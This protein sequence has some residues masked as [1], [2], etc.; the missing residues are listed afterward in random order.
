[1]KNAKMKS[2]LYI[3]TASCI[4][5][6]AAVCVLAIWDYVGAEVAWKTV[7][8][9]AVVLIGAM[10]FSSTNEQLGENTPKI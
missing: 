2:F 8:T 6:A 10:A 9:V 3:I 1:M 7:A 4:F 5:V